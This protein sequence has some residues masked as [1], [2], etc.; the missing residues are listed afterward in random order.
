MKTLPVGQGARA[1]GSAVLC[2]AALTLISGPASAKI[3]L[4][5]EIGELL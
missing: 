1:L 2:A 4:T 3:T 5:D